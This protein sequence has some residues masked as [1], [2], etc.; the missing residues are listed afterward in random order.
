MDPAARRGLKFY[1]YSWTVMG[2][3]AQM[4]IVVI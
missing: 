4:G 1:N 3:Q 2:F